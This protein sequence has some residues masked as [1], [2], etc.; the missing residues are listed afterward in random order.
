[1]RF[2]KS[3]IIF[4]EFLIRCDTKNRPNVWAA[5]FFGWRSN[6]RSL[7]PFEKVKLALGAF[8]RT[9]QAHLEQGAIAIHAI[10]VKIVLVVEPQLPTRPTAEDRIRATPVRIVAKLSEHLFHGFP[11]PMPDEI[12]RDLFYLLGPFA[13]PLKKTYLQRADLA[14]TKIT[15]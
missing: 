13:V 3:Q 4:N 12:V 8:G 2:W 5:E 14:I 11:R 10:G 6:A 15:P 1:M 9:G 7:H